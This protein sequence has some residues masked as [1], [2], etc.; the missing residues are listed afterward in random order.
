MAWNTHLRLEIDAEFDENTARCV[1]VQDALERVRAKR[2]DRDHVRSAEAW[3]QMRPHER[4]AYYLRRRARRARARCRD[5]APITCLNPRCAAVFVAL[6]A[7]TKYCTHACRHRASGL[8]SHYARR[9]RLRDTRRAMCP[10]CECTFE[11][12]RSD[13]LYC[14]DRCYSRAQARRRV[15]RMIATRQ[16]P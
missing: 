4:R 1:A 6:D 9:A 10:V 11:R 14:S 13:E 3:R 8:R 7:K 15:A 5:R 2:I 16:G 12:W